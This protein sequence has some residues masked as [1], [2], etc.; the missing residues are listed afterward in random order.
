MLIN[1][2]HKGAYA[3]TLAKCLEMDA[4]RVHTA[5]FAF[6]KALVFFP[7]YEEDC[8]EMTLLMEV[9]AERLPRETP[10][11]GAGHALRQFVHAVP[12][13][14]NALMSLAIGKAFEK[15]LAIDDHNSL[16]LEIVITAVQTTLDV[17]SLHAWFRPLGWQLSIEEHTIGVGACGANACIDLRLRGKQTLPI[18]LAQLQVLLCAMDHDHL[19]WIG[20][21]ETRALL[22]LTNQH[23]ASH[24][25]LAAITH[26]IAHYPNFQKRTALGNLMEEDDEASKAPLLFPEGHAAL[27]A[28]ALAQTLTLLRENPFAKV[29]L[30]N[31]TSAEWAQQIAAELQVSNVTLVH[32]DV[33]VLQGI[34]HQL[35]HATHIPVDDKRKMSLVPNVPSFKNPQFLGNDVVV[36]LGVRATL[37]ARQWPAIESMLL[38]YLR[39]KRLIWIENDATQFENW[40][41]GITKAFPYALQLHAHGAAFPDLQIA[42]FDATETI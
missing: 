21:D 26:H 18:A 31:A 15:A 16:Q 27:E 28:A 7:Q 19:Y 17:S 32:H 34:L 13:T 29:L 25:Q 5:E 2:L 36:V 41:S 6:G 20:E 8:C 35:N 24:P 1:I 37:P 30:V 14:S 11:T 23:F 38:G 4:E 40:A 42:V 3:K 12:Y 9:A 33:D 22:L 39:P 10:F